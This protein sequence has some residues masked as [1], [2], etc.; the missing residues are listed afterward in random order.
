MRRNR[1]LSWFYRLGRGAQAALLAKP[2]AYL[3]DDVAAEIP[4]HT[5]LAHRD[6]TPQ[7]PRRWQLRPAE[8]N[9]LE[10]ERH[11]LDDWWNDLPR[12]ARSALI[13]CRGDRVPPEY[14]A[15]VLDVIPGGAPAGVD[16]NTP[17]ALSGIAAAYVDMVACSSAVTRSNVVTG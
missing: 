1:T 6:E 4:G 5:V 16:L 10:D 14:R 15:A 8:A 3:P 13:E 17:F 2:H 7:L 11:R 9:L 12:H